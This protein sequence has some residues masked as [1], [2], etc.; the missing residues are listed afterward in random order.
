[1]SGRIMSGT[2]FSPTIGHTNR[3]LTGTP[4]Q[5]AVQILDDPYAANKSADQWLNPAAFTYPDWGTFSDL[6]TNTLLGPK[7]IQLDLALTRQINVGKQR[8]ELRAEV[9][10]FLF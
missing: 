4:N 10:N 1:M 9:F 8:V 2:W 3:A 6:A 5:R 7:S